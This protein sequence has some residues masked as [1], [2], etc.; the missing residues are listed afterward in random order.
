[1]NAQD[2]QEGAFEDRQN[3]VHL[4]RELADEA[5][6]RDMSAE[7]EQTFERQN[8]EID[9][10]D[11]VINEGLRSIEREQEAANALDE[12]RSSGTKL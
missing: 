1:M 7:E 10:L 8:A 5:E 9:R 2:I 6:G 4:L 12:F 11:E 3:A